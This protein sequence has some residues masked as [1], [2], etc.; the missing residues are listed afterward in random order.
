MRAIFMGT[1]FMVKFFI[2]TCTGIHNKLI[3]R[4]TVGVVRRWD[5]YMCQCV[6]MDA[7]ILGEYRIM[8]S[9]SLGVLLCGPFLWVRDLW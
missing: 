7:W 2:V 3:A 6:V 5:V 9:Y 4:D 8:E 1:G